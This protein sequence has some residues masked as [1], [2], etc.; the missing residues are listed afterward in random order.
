MLPW[1]PA[2][3]VWATTEECAAIARLMDLSLQHFLSKYTKSYSKRPGWR[4]LKRA[5]AS[6]GCLSAARGAQRRCG[7]MRHAQLPGSRHSL[8]SACCRALA[9]R[10]AWTL[11]L[12]LLQGSQDCVFLV[13]GTKCS[14]Y[15][16][17]PLQCA[18]Y[19]W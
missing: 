6:P 8:H 18:T 3:E 14:I 10:V 4:L 13:G 16:A 11:L 9:G 17:R 2:G 15:G 7:A 12:V 19:P 5:Q 1:L